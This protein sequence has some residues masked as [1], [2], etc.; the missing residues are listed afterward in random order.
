MNLSGSEGIDGDVVAAEVVMLR[1]ASSKTAV[2]LEGDSDE[3]FW[4]RF[5]DGDKCDLVVSH[6]K[7]NA[8]RAYEILRRAGYDGV[9]CIVDD[10]HD[11]LIG[12]RMLDDNIFYYDNGDLEGTLFGSSAFDK[13]LIEFGSKS[14]IQQIG[15]RGSHP[16]DEIIQ[17]CWW[18]AV[19]RFHSLR[20][21]N[22]M[23]FQGMSYGG[24]CKRTL[25]VDAEELTRE[26]CNRG[27]VAVPAPEA[28][29]ESL[30]IMKK[31]G[32]PDLFLVRG[33]DLTCVL[34]RSLQG[35]VGTLNSGKA[36]SEDIETALRLAYERRDLD[37]TQ[38]FADI[39]AWE[40][41]SLGWRV[42]NR[43]A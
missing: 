39:S 8:L 22:G 31:C 7:E 28:L 42:F 33:H 41:R 37:N 9:I 14:K 27:R 15:Q 10:D 21:G 2:L 34:A 16:K 17:A 1:A 30:T 43:A 12:S 11:L 35:Y 32:L 18:L 24:I 38:I 5:T 36:R 25:A 23:K 4:L 26:V 13:V 6:G 20:H 19:L 40:N 29:R 3:R